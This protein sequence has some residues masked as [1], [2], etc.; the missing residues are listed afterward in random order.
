M[1]LSV[2]TAGDGGKDWRRAG[3]GCEERCE[4]EGCSLVACCVVA[5]NPSSW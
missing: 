5:Y 1:P 3:G 2:Q 4:R